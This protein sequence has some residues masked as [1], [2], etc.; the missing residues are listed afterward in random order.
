ME[1]AWKELKETTYNTSLEELG[2]ATRKHKDCFDENNAEIKQLLED[3]NMAFKRHT[4][5]PNS[6][7]KKDALTNKSRILQK[8]LH[9]MQ[10]SWLSSKADEL[11]GFDDRNDW[12]KST[13]ALRKCM[14]IPLQAPHLY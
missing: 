14:T 11:Q 2:K 13:A 8:S 1:P 12:K 9:H 7:A 6:R 5:D 3:K 10:D 4:D